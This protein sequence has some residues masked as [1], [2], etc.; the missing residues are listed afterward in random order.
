MT[1]SI[2][3]DHDPVLNRGGFAVSLKAAQLVYTNVEKK[4]SSTGTEG[5][6]IWLKTPGFLS[7]GEETEIQSRLG[8]FEERKDA[9]MDGAM[10]ERHLY[11]TLPSGKAVIARCVPLAGSDKFNRGGRFFC[12]CADLAAG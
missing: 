2:I 1:R 3:R 4:L 6:Q 10:I 11:F 8:D 12:A 7:D 5:F 9:T